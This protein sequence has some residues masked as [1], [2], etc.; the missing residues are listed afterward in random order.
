VVLDIGAGSLRS[1]TAIAL[2]VEL[3]FAI[4]HQRSLLDRSL[5]PSNLTVICTDARHWLYPQSITTAV[6]LIRHCKHLSFVLAVCGGQ[7]AGGL[8]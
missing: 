4:G 5:I 8:L 6:L 7:A 1:A 3:V 2:L